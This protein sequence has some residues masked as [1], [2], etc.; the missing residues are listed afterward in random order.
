MERTEKPNL[1]LLER[2]ELV[3]AAAFES[4][5]LSPQFGQVGVSAKAQIADFQC[6]GA[7]AAARQTRANPS[8]V[9]RQVVAN[10]RT[11]IDF[12]DFA[13][14]EVA[15]PGFI[16]F[17]VTD[18]ALAARTNDLV[19]DA[20]S[21]HRPTD[22]PSK[23]IIDYGGPNAAKAMHV[24]HLRSAVIG[25][26][27]KD[28]LRFQGHE[29]IGDIHLG[30]WGLQM[31]QLIMELQRARPDLPYFD[32]DARGP[33]PKESPLTM[34]D[35][36]TL[37]PQ[38]SA[39][40]KDDPE[41]REAARVATAELQAGRPGYRAL[42]QHFVD[43]SIADI[44]RDYGRMGVDFEQWFGESRYQGR[45]VDL[46][47]RLMA[48]GIAV[49]SEG[50]IVIPVAKDENDKIPPLML[51]NSDEGF[52][53]GATDIA[54]IDERVNEFGAD[55]CLYVVDARQSLHFEQVF[56]AAR[57]SVAAG[58]D[59]DFEHLAFGTVNGL[60][61]KPFKTREGGVMRLA[62]L[63]EMLVA[64]A[65][66]RIEEAGIGSE[67]TESER[68]QVAETVGLGALK[69]ADL[70]HDR[71]S[72]YV[73]DI[74][75]FSKFEGR[76]GPYLQYAGV[77]IKS[78]LSRAASGNIEFAPV[79]ISEPIERQIA[80]NLDRFHL[81]V[82]RSAKLRKPHILAEHMYLLASAYNNF[83]HGSRILIENDKAR[84]GSWLSLSRA[85]LTQLEL[86]L[87]LLGITIPERM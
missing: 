43:V 40:C 53:Y 32:P 34:E 9:A 41:A 87:S 51:R 83:Y 47:K 58:K 50:A 4:C 6:N 63:M 24:G 68:E 48:E 79:Q 82:E 65:Q 76:T 44:R 30:D 38:A 33:F 11:R 2:I 42:W 85:V 52:G 69:F 39:R 49:E 10:L 25:Q 8:E 60:D 12:A 71:E 37:Y 36:L 61:G 67:L 31:G 18:A 66:R 16:N 15:G 22:H 80:L 59:I 5:G 29:V 77:R 27:L 46:T 81:T 56:R 21:G 78:L 74:G 7:M 73:F 17:V 75:R 23:I 70:Q 13:T 45:L 72:D 62:D 20:R 19:A 35:L 84:A 64:E 54:T 86:G 26:S 57:K 14:V 55:A 1:S 28:I 3:T